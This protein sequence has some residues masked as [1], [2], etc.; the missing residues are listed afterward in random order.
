MDNFTAA[1]SACTLPSAARITSGGS[2]HVRPRIR[3]GRSPARTIAK[4]VMRGGSPSLNT[5]GRRRTTVSSAPLAAD[6]SL[7]LDVTGAN[8]VPDGAVAVALNITATQADAPGFLT[9]YPCGTARPTTS[10]VNYAPGENVA[11]MAQV[12]VGAGGQICLYALSKVDVVVDLLGWYGPGATAGY[13]A[14]AIKWEQTTITGVTTTPIVLTGYFS[15]T[16][17]PNHHNFGGQYIF[18]PR[19]EPGLS[20]ATRDE[21]ETADIAY[22][23]IIDQDGL[24]DEIWVVGLDGALRRL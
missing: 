7:S 19:L 4:R 13:T 1:Y 10:T 23:A 5:I 24:P 12:R 6:C 3:S 21:L 17:A 2:T 8:G 14:P 11:N 16:Y 18:D 22:F 20:Q 15:Q 9:V